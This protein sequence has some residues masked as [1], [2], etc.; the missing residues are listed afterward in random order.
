VR[1]VRSEIRS[2]DISER[3]VRTF[4]ARV[5]TGRGD[6]C[7]EWQ[8]PRNTLGYGIAYYVRPA[9]QRTTTTAHRLSYALHVGAAP[10]GL[11]LDHLCRNPGCVNPTHLEPVT[12]RVNCLRGN[13]PAAHQA[14]QRECIRGHLLSGENL[15]I[16]SNGSRVCRTCNAARAK[17]WRDAKA[18]LRVA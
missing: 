10:A 4:L 15:L 17:A 8:G 13:A 9:G 1:A 18:P 2:E 16:R 7:W 14:K 11:V 3:R 12:D 6:A 5:S